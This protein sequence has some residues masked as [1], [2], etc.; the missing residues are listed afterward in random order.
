MNKRQYKKQFKKKYGIT[1]DQFKKKYG[2]TPDQF[3]YMINKVFSKEV[4]DPIIKTITDAAKTAAALV[5]E[6]KNTY[7]HCAM[8]G[9][10]ILQKDDLIIHHKMELSDDNVNNTLISLNPDN[11]ECVCF[12]C[13]NKVHER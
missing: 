6:F 12:S 13:H 5:A 9:K 7:G 4:M 8:C 3:N 1:P 11:L 10:P 2:I